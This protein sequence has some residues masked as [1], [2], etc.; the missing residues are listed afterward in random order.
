[1]VLVVPYPPMLDHLKQIALL[2]SF[3]FFGLDYLFGA[4]L[5]V[6]Y[7]GGLDFQLVVYIFG[8]NNAVRDCL[9]ET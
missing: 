8:A 4:E 1:M 7:R 2:V 3:T 5:L 9:D 6:A